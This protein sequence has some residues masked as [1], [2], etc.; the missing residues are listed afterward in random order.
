MKKNQM[1]RQR[2]PP[3]PKIEAE[4]KSGSLGFILG[5]TL[6][7][8]AVPFIYP[9]IML[10]VGMLPTIVAMFTVRDEDKQGSSITAIG[11][12]NA[13]GLTPFII[14]LWEKGQ[15]VGAALEILRDT[16]NMAGDVRRRRCGPIDIICRA[17]GDNVADRWPAR[18]RASKLLKQN[19]ETIKNIWGSE[20]ATTK[21]LEKIAKGE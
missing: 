14:E 11:V 10:M 17:A 12:M 6:F 4:E 3:K 20:V 13:A 21:P 7:G 18:N 2:H 15:T 8:A 9:T 1:R 16:G 5:M 19:L